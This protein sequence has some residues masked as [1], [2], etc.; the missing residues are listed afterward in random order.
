MS[1]ERQ[2]YMILRTNLTALPMDAVSNQPDKGSRRE[3]ELKLELASGKVKRLLAHPLLAGAQPVP[4][5][6]GTLHAVYYDTAGQALRRAG[7]SLRIRTRD[8]RHIQTVKAERKVRGLSLD[9]GEWE[10]PVEGTLNFEAALGTPLAPFVIDEAL[11]E[12]IQPAFAVDTDR[13]AFL[14]EQDGAVIEVALDKAKA[15]AEDRAAEFCEV[16]LELKR[17]EP[18]SLFDFARGLAE[19][20]PLRLSPV[21]KSER[22]YDLLGHAAAKPV[23]SGKVRIPHDATSAEAFQI[24]ARSS[25]SQ[26]VRNEALFRVCRD[27]EV[28]HQMRV[29]F[30]RLSAAISLFKP[31]LSDKESNAVRAELRWASKKLGA[32]RDLDVLIGQLR[33]SEDGKTDKSDLEKAERR[34]AEA[35]DA[36]LKTLSKPR[37]MRTVL[38]AAIWIES[39]Q[40]LSRPKPAR[41]AAR[42]LPAETQAVRELSRRWK[43]ISRQASR[44]ADLDEEARHKLRLRIKK[45]RYGVEFFA[46]LFPGIPARERRRTISSILERLQDVLGELNDIG[47]GYSLLGQPASRPKG[48]VKRR[49]KKLLSQAEAASGKL[50]KA[51]PFW[52]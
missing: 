24:M 30:R 46:S 47:V 2:R 41:Q 52:T 21:T 45:L 15:S 27:V 17:G 7:I 18:R 50:L 42:Q 16:E 25:L 3:V 12:K 1:L 51:E 35:Y 13:Q 14:V 19:A 29:G 43:R 23:T 28:L 31:M 33:K 8:G 22:G 44:M 37:F 48:R 49:F 40:W 26:I 32:A 34:R 20:A 6:S 4:E 9:R 39:G 38:N 36:L 5:Q 11:R 10:T